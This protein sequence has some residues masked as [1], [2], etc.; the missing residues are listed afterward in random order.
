MT[1]LNWWLAR[2]VLAAAALLFLLVGS[3][4]ILDPV[5]AA[6]GS[7]MSLPTLLGR[8]NTR[9][10]VGGL[11]LGTALISVVCLAS[12]ARV[13]TGLWFVAGVDAPV[14]LIRIYGV[15]V[16]GTL[17]ASRRILISETVLLVLVLGALALTRRTASVVSTTT[18]ARRHTRGDVTAA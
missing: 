3:K 2:L 4:Y 10:G 8:T 7:G 15:L 1:R 16:D 14:L 12:R 18:T 6:A 17:S 9:A 5:S 13:R 11:F